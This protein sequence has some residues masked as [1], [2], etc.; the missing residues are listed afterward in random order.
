MQKEN[1]KWICCPICGGKT[2][3]AL[4]YLHMGENCA[5]ISMEEDTYEYK[6]RGIT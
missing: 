3:Y 4:T 1:M 2:P 5:I 6:N